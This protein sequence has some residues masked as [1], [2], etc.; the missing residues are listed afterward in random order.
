MF[1]IGKKRQTVWTSVL[2][3][4][5]LS[6]N[7]QLRVGSMLKARF[8]PGL[9]PAGRKLETGGYFYYEVY[10]GLVLQFLD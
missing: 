5:I 2:W 7:R 3:H 6:T 4:M 8:F 1:I 9:Q 10:S